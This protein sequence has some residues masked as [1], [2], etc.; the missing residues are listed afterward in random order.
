MQA[1]THVEVD[2]LERLG[3]SALPDVHSNP[4][5]QEDRHRQVRKEE[6]LGGLA[7]IGVGS[8]NGPDS[9]D[10]ESKVSPALDG[11]LIVDELL[12]RTM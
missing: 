11:G 6:G 1:E 2:I 9:L 8:A 3:E 5:S 4:E 10:E 12:P 7:R